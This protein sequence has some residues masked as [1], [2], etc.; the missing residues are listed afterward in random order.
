MD[1]WIDRRT[2]ESP[3][4]RLPPSSLTKLA[5]SKEGEPPLGQ[6]VKHNHHHHHLHHHYHQHAY[7]HHRHQGKLQPAHSLLNIIIIIAVTAV[8]CNFLFFC[9]CFM[10]K[11]SLID[12]LYTYLLS[13]HFEALRALTYLN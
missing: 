9:F 7:H 11:K 12:I 6:L 5:A 4:C 10:D 13:F 8:G 3:G 2:G 1:G